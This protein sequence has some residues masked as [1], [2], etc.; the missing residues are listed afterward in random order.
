M[1]NGLSL[2]EYYGLNQ[3]FLK[4]PKHRGLLEP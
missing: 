2:S 1:E 4:I 3:E